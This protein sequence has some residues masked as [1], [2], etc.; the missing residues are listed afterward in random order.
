MKYYNFFS[1]KWLIASIASNF[2]SVSSSSYPVGACVFREHRQRIYAVHRSDK[3]SSKRILWASCVH[4]INRL[5]VTQQLMSSINMGCFQEEKSFTTTCPLSQPPAI[6]SSHI[7]SA[8]SW[9][10]A[11]SHIKAMEEIITNNS[12]GLGFM[13]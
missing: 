5:V 6:D 2:Y 8:G 9:G 7:L 12:L 10:P 13:Y 3:V 4:F 1:S 11:G